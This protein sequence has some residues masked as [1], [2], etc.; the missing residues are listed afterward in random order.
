MSAEQQPRESNLS[1]VLGGPA[2]LAGLLLLVSIAGAQN[3]VA[4][5]DVANLISTAQQNGEKMSPRVFDYSWKSKTVVRNYKK[6]R[7]ASETEQDHEAYPAPGLTYVAKKLVKENGLPLSAKRAAKEEQRLN[8]ELMV[9]EVQQAMSATATTDPGKETGCPPFGIWTVLTGPGGKETSLGISDFLCLSTFFAPRSERRDG[10]ET[11]VLFFRPRENYEKSVPEK[12]PFAKLV[13]AIWIDAED[14]VVSHIEAWPTDN[15]ETFNNTLP[16]GPAPIV[17]DDMR[18]PDG[19]WV[20]RF[21]YVDTRNNPLAFNGLNMEWKQEFS[22]YQRYSTESKD[23]TIT[24]PK[25]ED[26]NP[27][28]P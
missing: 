4:T 9:A 8:R 3:T 19:M 13:G 17:F 18:L 27:L 15:P 23:Y 10:R 26:K 21:R 24:A 28:N 6:S 5:V 11:I 12:T 1:T 2:I 22:G 20:R 25:P 14:K 16:A 7:L